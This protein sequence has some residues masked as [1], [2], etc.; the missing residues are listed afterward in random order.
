MF[1]SN[2]SPSA[3]LARKLVITL[4]FESIEFFHYQVK[5]AIQTGES[6]LPELEH[7]IE[8]SSLF[9]AVLTDEFVRSRWCL[10]EL[11][12][13]LRRRAEGRLEILPFVL[14]P[15]VLDNLAL[16]GLGDIQVEN[17]IGSDEKEVAAQ[18]V[19]K[20]DRALKSP[21]TSSSTPGGAPAIAIPSP[22]VLTEQQR[23]GLVEIIAARLTV[24]DA[25]QRP[26]WIKTLLVRSLLYQHLAGEDYTGSAGAAALRLVEKCEGLGVLPDGRRALILL[27]TGLRTQVSGEH[28]AALDALNAALTQVAA[29][30]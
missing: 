10:F 8:E 19:K 25:A 29:T 22:G 18:I 7:R 26:I 20:I 21:Q 5:D 13:A 17:M 15:G 11:Q 14:S 16:L 9:L 28:V 24:E 4:R 27:V 23:S 3:P 1:I 2:A 12:V 6:W 30:G